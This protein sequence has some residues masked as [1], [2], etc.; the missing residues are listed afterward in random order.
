MFSTL[1]V[2]IMEATPLSKL[3]TDEA[4]LDCQHTEPKG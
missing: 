3:M 1:T 4:A 2:P